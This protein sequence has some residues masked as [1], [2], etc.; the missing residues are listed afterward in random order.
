MAKDIFD[1]Y[2]NRY[3]LQRKVKAIISPEPSPITALFKYID[4]NL[5]DVNVIMGVSKK[6]GDEARFKSAEKYYADNEHIHLYNPLETAV[7]PYLDKN[8]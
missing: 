5:Q 4:D 8:G 7:E 6:G 3:N 2:I 1:I